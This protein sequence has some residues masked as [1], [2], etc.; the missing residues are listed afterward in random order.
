METIKLECFNCEGDGKND[1]TYPECNEPASACCGGCYVKYE[2]ETCNGSGELYPKN[3]EIE[4]YF[5]MVIAYGKML[6]GFSESLIEIN[7]MQNLVSEDAFME[8]E[9]LLD[10][11]HKDGQLILKEQIQRIN[12]H[13]VILMDIIKREYE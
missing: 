11:G 9:L 8:M 7:K 3:E 10:G 5:L 1:G 4:D 2:C 12:K 6:K 13:L